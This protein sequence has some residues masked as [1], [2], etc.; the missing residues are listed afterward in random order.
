MEADRWNITLLLDYYGGTLTAK[1][2]EY[3]DL[4]YNEDLSLS[5][6][7]EITGITRPGVHNI[8]SRSRKKLIELERCTGIVERFLS[9]R[10]ELENAALLAER[11][12]ADTELVVM[13]SEVAN[14]I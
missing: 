1:Q 12:G 13:L 3:L 9:I 4:Y 11:T 14:G 8:I 5:E 10:S 6:I 7:A 2:R